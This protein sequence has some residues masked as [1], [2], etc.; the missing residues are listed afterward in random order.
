[1]RCPVCGTNGIEGGVCFYCEAR[2][3]RRK[4]KEKPERE[5]TETPETGSP[6][7]GEEDERGRD[8]GPGI[9]DEG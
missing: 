9:R 2:E 4:A 3:G 7:G 5:G 6:G 1:M 8:E